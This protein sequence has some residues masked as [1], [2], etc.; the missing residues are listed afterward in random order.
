MVSGKFSLT[1]KQF[2]AFNIEQT[3]IRAHF[4][5]LGPLSTTQNN[6]QLTSITQL[7]PRGLGLTLKS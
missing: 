2:V 3:L 1:P 4:Q 7:V 5:A 6:S